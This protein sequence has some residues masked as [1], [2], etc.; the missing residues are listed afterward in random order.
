M[1]I[2][3]YKAFSED[4]TN[5]YGVPFDEGKQY[6]VSG[7]ISFGNEG[8]GYHMCTHISDVFRYVD[9]VSSEVK[10]AVVIGSGECVCFN[11]EYEGYYDMYACEEIY[12]ERILTREEVISLMLKQH[13]FD[14]MKFIKTFKMNYNETLL[15]FSAFKGRIDI[16]K[17][18][19]YYQ[20]GCKD[21]YNTGYKRLVLKYGQNCD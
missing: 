15:F 6:K 1:E 11:D 13:D 9:A 14:V 16:E 20:C 8:N 18:L 3:G 12:I 7:K 10:V 2:K 21:V 19:L 4:L 17:M 5:K